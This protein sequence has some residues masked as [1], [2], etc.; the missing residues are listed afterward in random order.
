MNKIVL[1]AAAATAALFSTAASAEITWT[2]NAGGFAGKGDVQTPLSWD[3]KNLQ[4]NATS[5]AFS[6]HEN[7]SYDVACYKI[8]EVGGRQKR[9]VRT[10]RDFAR[11]DNIQMG[12]VEEVRNGK[13]QVTGFNVA[14]ISLPAI[15][16]Q[17]GGEW[18]LDYEDPKG[19]I[20]NLVR[21][22]GQLQAN[23]VVL[24]TYIPTYH[25]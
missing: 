6:Y 11:R 10:D 25:D 2:H 19:L 13:K 15:V 7:R 9:L 14:S 16:P 1:A 22:N 3:N 4:A 23:G 20:Q 5:V 12:I 24:P 17:C 21:D 8:D 18:Q